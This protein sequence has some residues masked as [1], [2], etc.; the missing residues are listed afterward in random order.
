MAQ[1]SSV[2]FLLRSLRKETERERG[3]DTHQ[4]NNQMFK[5]KKHLIFH[6]QLTTIPFQFLP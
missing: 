3:K 4:V 1:P 6:L 2:L 5:L